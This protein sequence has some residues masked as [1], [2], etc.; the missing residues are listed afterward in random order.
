MLKTHSYR[1]RGAGR[2][3]VA[4]LVLICLTGLIGVVA[5]VIDGGLLLAQRRHCQAVADAAALAAASVLYLEYPANAGHD[6]DGN[7]AAAALALASDNGCNNDGVH[8]TVTVHIPPTSGSYSGQYGFAEVIVTYNQPRL[9][10]GIFGSSSLA[11]PARAV[12]Q[13]TWLGFGAGII[14]LAPTGSG[15]FSANGNGD[16]T[17][18]SSGAIVDSNS[19]SALTGVGNA[20]FS[21][22]QF[23]ITGGYS[24]GSNTTISGQVNTGVHPTPDPLAYLPEPTAPSPTFSAVNFNGKDPL[25]LSP[26][27][28]TG[29]ISLSGKGAVTLSAGIYYM[30]GG[31]FTTTGQGSLTGN[32]VM[33]FNANGTVKLAGTGAVNLTP[34]TSGLYQGMMIF[35]A[36]SNG[37]PMS[38]T[39]N[40]GM[41][42]KGT[43]YAPAATLAL[44]GNGGTNSMGSQII[45][46]MVSVGGN[47]VIDVSYQ[48]GAVAPAR[49]ITLVE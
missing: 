35:Q 14:A 5:I 37:S 18:L 36:R 2:G 45:C 28:Y 4:P 9:F 3:I 17:I 24:L 21:A 34:P 1:R 29:G 19:T 39:G 10:S 48:E 30:N 8:S 26:G 13:G 6:S 33:I 38:I 49:I 16:I 20:T 47:G 40:G 7:A 23:N 46:N 31:G 15:T 25:T 43:I 11:V 22:T 32:G 41:V 42:I 44:N 27:T 12:A